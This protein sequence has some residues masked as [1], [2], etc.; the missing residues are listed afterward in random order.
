MPAVGSRATTNRDGHVKSRSWAFLG[1]GIWFALGLVAFAAGHL[2][3]SPGDLLVV[4]PAV[5][6]YLLASLGDSSQHSG[7][8]WDSAHGPPF[9]TTM[10]IVVV[11]FLPALIAFAWQL[12]KQ[13]SPA[14]R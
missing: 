14:R 10:G 8:L 1:A 11:Y 7:V 12:S 4:L 5:P 9:L 3:F 6:L 2:G 13:S